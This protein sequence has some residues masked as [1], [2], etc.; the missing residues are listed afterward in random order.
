VIRPHRHRPTRRRPD[1]S[2][3]RHNP[4][5]FLVTRRAAS[6]EIRRHPRSTPRGA[7]RS[8]IRLSI[9]RRANP[10]ELFHGDPSKTRRTQ[11]GAWTHSSQ[12]GRSTAPWALAAARTDSSGKAAGRSS[13]ERRLAS[14]RAPASASCA[15]P[16]SKRIRRCSRPPY[17][18]SLHSG[19]FAPSRAAPR[20]TTI[21]SRSCSDN[22]SLS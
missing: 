3:H 16:S 12:A 15:D 9:R 7:C 5:L 21:G 19:P 6:R 20:S 10:A 1:R 4:R 8:T 18:Q 22:E 14:L 13:A 17:C 2:R 11:T